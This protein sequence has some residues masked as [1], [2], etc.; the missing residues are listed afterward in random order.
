MNHLELF[1]RRDFFKGIGSLATISGALWTGGCESCSKQIA[2]RPTRR[3]ISNLPAN[4]PIIQTY[5]AAVTAMKGLPSSDHRNWT[6]QANIHFNSCPHG[7]WFFLPWHRAYLYYF[8]R[9][10]RQLTGNQDFALPYWNWTTHPGVP[11]VF[12]G[13]SS[14]PLFDGTRAI[15]QSDQADPSWVGAPVI[16]NILSQTSFVLFASDA[17]QSGNFHFAGPTGTGMLEGTPHNSIHGW[18]GGDMGAFHS[19]LDPVFWTHHNML[20]CLWVDWNINE[21]N[22]NTSDTSWSSRQFTDFFDENG[23]AA[24]IEVLTTVLFPIFTYQFEP[25]APN[26]TT[27]KIQGQKLEQFLRAGAPSKF[28]FAARFPLG[29]SITA[30]TGVNGTGAIP[31]PTDALRSVL[32]PGSRNRAVLT[33]GSVDLPERND[34]FMRVFV[35]KPDAAAETPISDPHY[36]GSF[37][38][39]FDESMPHMAGHPKPGYLVDLSPALQKLN[40]AGSLGSG[41]LDI[42]LVAV[43]YG[44]RESRG[45][46]ITVERL[47]V[48]VARF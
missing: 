44:H 15:T 20:D 37:A 48:G 1:S 12:W 7:N 8:E 10:C 30:G 4:D 26:E 29:K 39:F 43:P 13:D 31:V 46:S 47:E 27:S 36:A 40:Q 24:I 14:N 41:Q 17:P 5:K 2:A 19:P 11:D 9:I 42:S 33:V 21:N 32:Q 6:N 34:F 38:F 23:N 3:N 25:C 28:D 35:N 16:E 22:A 45:K 18:I